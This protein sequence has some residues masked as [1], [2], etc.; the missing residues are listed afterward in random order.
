MRKTV[1]RLATLGLLAAL[2]SAVPVGAEENEDDSPLLTDKY[3]NRLEASCT[4]FAA[5]KK[6]GAEA[7][8]DFSLGVYTIYNAV[9]FSHADVC[10]SVKMPKLQEL[11]KLTESAVKRVQTEMPDP[12]DFRSD[13]LMDA[14][15]GSLVRQV[16]PACAAKMVSFEF[17]RPQ[18]ELPQIVAPQ[19][20]S[21]EQ[22][23]DDV[24]A[25]ELFYARHGIYSGVKCARR[26]FARLPVALCQAPDAGGNMGGLFGFYSTGIAA[27]NGT[28]MG[29]MKSFATIEDAD[30]KPIAIVPIPTPA[31]S[32]VPK[33]M[34]LWE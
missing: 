28:A 27:M 17:A 25:L 2:V 24:E 4:A 3:L 30:A 18:F 20:A 11:G 15:Y 26:E 5:G 6:T 23:A 32:D 19:P 1:R 31:R 22:A 7:C 29:H 8:S 16:P 33:I 12:E 34:E 14:L 21:P 10:G 9:I 13:L